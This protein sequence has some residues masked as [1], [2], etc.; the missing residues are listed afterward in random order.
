MSDPRLLVTTSPFLKDSASTAWIMWHVSLSLAPVVLVATW[1]FGGSVPLVILA[2]IAGA[3]VPEGIQTILRRNARQPQAPP[4]RDG[5]AFLTGLLLALTLPPGIPLWMAFLGGLVSVVLGKTV[6]GGIG[7]N[8]FNPALVGRAFLQAAFPAT[9]TSWLPVV[10]AGSRTQLPATL[11]TTPLL[12]AD[13]DAISAATPL[14]QATF[15]Q[16]TPE[17]VDLMFGAVPGS[18]GETG[19]LVIL[20][21]GLYLAVRGIVNWRIPLSILATVWLV[22]SGLHLLDPAGYPGGLFHLSTGGLMLGAWFMASDPVT[23]PMTQAGCWVFG[24]LIGVLI[25]V[26]RV[27]GGLPE[28]VMYAILFANA[29]TPLINRFTQPRTFGTRFKPG[30][31]R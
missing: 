4:L 29:A 15:G 5:S 12:A 11:F 9:M 7:A 26:I 13:V 31:T 18:L 27:F 30:F 28:G 25:V 16:P 14:S 17:F 19:A 21:A 20:L 23:S 10:D 6:F 24:A 22:G 8:V 1:F 2:A 3:T